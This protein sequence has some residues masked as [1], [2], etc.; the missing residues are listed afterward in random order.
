MLPHFIW[1]ARLEFTVG[2]ER[3]GIFEL[4]W[5]ENRQNPSITFLFDRSR[6]SF[7][8]HETLLSISRWICG[9]DNIYVVPSMKFSFHRWCANLIQVNVWIAQYILSIIHLFHNKFMWSYELIVF[10]LASWI[11][12]E[13]SH[14]FSTPTGYLTWTWFGAHICRHDTGLLIFWKKET[15]VK[16][17]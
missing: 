17:I 1:D 2:F 12:S 10:Y 6:A 5:F 11:E 16:L 13:S 15:I 14:P 4:S 7:I 9:Y 3:F 8:D